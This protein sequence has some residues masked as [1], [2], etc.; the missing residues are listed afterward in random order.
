ME[1]DYIIVSQSLDF[2]SHS[3]LVH[4]RVVAGFGGV[5]G[6]FSGITGGFSGVAGGFS[7]VAGEFSGDLDQLFSMMG[8]SSA[9]VVAAAASGNEA[10]VRQHLSK[11]PQDVCSMH[12]SV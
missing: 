6:G 3:G 7:G 4:R 1:G 5:T 8:Q 12:P 11:N 10:T 9:V 2:L